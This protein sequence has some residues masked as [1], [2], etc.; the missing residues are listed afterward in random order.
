MYPTVKFMIDRSRTKKVGDKKYTKIH[1]RPSY[2]GSRFKRNTNLM[3][4][5][6]K[7]NT[8]AT[9]VK[10]NTPE[11]ISLRDKLNSIKTMLET[12]IP[13]N[14]LKEH[15]KPIS[16]H[17]YLVTVTDLFNGSVPDHQE[18]PVA[19]N[20]I[21]LFEDYIKNHCPQDSLMI[22]NRVKKNL[23]YYSRLKKATWRCDQI[24]DTLM[25]GWLDFLLNTEYK[26]QGRVVKEK[27][28]NGTAEGYLKKI[29]AVLKQYDVEVPADITVRGLTGKMKFEKSYKDIEAVPTDEEIRM[30]EEY[31]PPAED[32]VT[33]E[34]VRDLF[35]FCCYTG[36]R[37]NETFWATIDDL[38]ENMTIDGK[39]YIWNYRL[40]KN[41]NRAS[42]YLEVFDK[43]VAIIKKWESRDFSVSR[44]HKG[45]KEVNFK[46]VLPFV[47]LSKANY[48]LH[49]IL[50]EIGLNKVETQ[51]KYRGEEQLVNEI[52]R[53]EYITFHSSRH[54]AIMNYIDM[55]LMPSDVSAVLGVSSRTLEKYYAKSNRKKV[56]TKIRDAY[57]RKNA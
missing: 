11:D 6:K 18:N 33:R 8:A 13:D 12:T 34:K 4:E 38:E 47:A 50:A 5:V 31:V 54:Y 20:L 7:W 27:L 26:E 32:G 45:I 41:E 2:Q 35:L 39:Q 14:Y 28:T 46:P 10:G 17:D 19:K 22:Y 24:T 52:P 1:V 42:N 36:I 23:Q 16:F 3:V 56:F 15:G 43:A 21:L 37:H 55:G 48:Y 25:R 51:I 30:L 49:K 29:R 57:R 40:S 44:T 53:Y 9:T